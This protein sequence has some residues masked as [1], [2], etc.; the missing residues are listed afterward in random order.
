GV[1]RIRF[2]A[3]LLPPAPSGIMDYLRVLLVPFQLTTVILVVVFS[4]L[5]SVFDIAGIYGIFAS[6][7]LQIWVLKYCYVLIEQLAEGAGEPPVMSTDML[8]PFEARPW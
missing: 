4:L 2:H 6:L 5:L 3:L 1:K 8:S 7:F